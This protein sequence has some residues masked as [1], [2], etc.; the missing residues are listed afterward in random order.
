MANPGP[1]P[2]VTPEDVLEVFDERGDASE[3][4]TAPEV[5]DELGCSRRTALNK[6][7]KLADRGSVKSKKVGGRSRV[8]WRSDGDTP[9]S[10]PDF[11]SG[12]GAFKGTDL[13]DHVDDV[14]EELD[15][16]FRERED[17]S[18]GQ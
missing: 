2:R 5:A 7:H 6:L 10:T 1:K 16:G 8:W 12:F 14:S 3:P 4:L 13:A 11:R 18:T 17:A 9:D 15:R